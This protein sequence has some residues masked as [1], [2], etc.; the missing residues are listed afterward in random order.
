MLALSHDTTPGRPPDEAVDVVYALTSPEIFE[1]LVRQCGWTA[2]Q[3]QDW[4]ADTLTRLL[5]DPATTRR[6]RPTPGAIIST[7]T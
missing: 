3:F 6:R 2:Q 1:L 7:W 5:L 4:L